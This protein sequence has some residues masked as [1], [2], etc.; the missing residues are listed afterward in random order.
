MDTVKA[1]FSYGLGE[2]LEN[3][4]LM[5]TDDLDG[6]GNTLD[7]KLTGNSGDNLL[8]GGAGADILTGKGGADI[9]IFNFGQSLVNA[10]DWI[11]DFT[12]G[13]DKIDLL[14]QGGWNVNAPVSL[15][16]A[17]DN[18]AATLTEVMTQVFTDA[19][20]AVE[21][22]QALGINSAALVKVT[23]PGIR[24]TY[25]VVNNTNALFQA[26]KDLLINITGLK[27]GLPDFGAVPVDSFFV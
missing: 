12:L 20:G 16:R 5:G 8:N 14:T 15:T 27:G 21:G 4:T 13:E 7:N 1:Y 25:L 6:I 9:F 2:N 26:D 19:N 24:G 18:K 3:L 10:S 22:N 11:K 23:T 17:A